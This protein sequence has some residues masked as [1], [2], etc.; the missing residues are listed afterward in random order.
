MLTA[1][2]LS[3]LGSVA[4]GFFTRQGG[5]SE[6]TYTSLNCGF[7]SQDQAER[8]AENRRRAM[9]RLDLAGE[10]L[11]TV[12]QIHSPDVARVEAAWAPGAVPKADAM[13][14]DRPGV[15]L[16]ILTADCVPVLFADPHA[17]V[18]G[19]AHAGWKGALNGVIEATVAA[20]EALGAR[21][22]AIIAASGPAIAQASYEVGPEFPAPF[23]AQDPEN[24]RFF[25]PSTR[26][27][28]FRFDIKGYVTRCITAA[29]VAS[30]ESL[31]QDT[32]AEGDQFFSYRRNCHQKIEDYGR[33]LSAIALK[34]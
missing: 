16:G 1:D 2:G 29:G 13:V 5:V 3:A 18:I 7:G 33:G 25:I 17:R 14:T 12:H 26:E 30:A 11:L 15:A 20:M 27:G 22:H 10:D 23:Q 24:E 28:H 8:V 4:H 21:R 34:D 6:G 32:Y 19:A 9:G 31:P